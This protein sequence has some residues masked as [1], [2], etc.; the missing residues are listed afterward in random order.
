MSDRDEHRHLH[1]SDGPDEDVST[2]RDPEEPPAPLPP[3]GTEKP[4]FMHPQWTVG[5]VLILGV[6]AIVAGLQNPI[7][8]L[9]GSP[10]ILTLGIYAWTR[11]VR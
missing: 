8:F 4:V 2:G 5:V 9:I 11:F 10:F 3:M 6:V 1:E 7:W